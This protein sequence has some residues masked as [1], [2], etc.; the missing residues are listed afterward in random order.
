MIYKTKKN[1]VYDCLLSSIFMQYD[2]AMR[3]TFE[4]IYISEWNDRFNK[5]ENNTLVS[6]VFLFFVFTII[7]NSILMYFDRNSSH[8]TRI[9][10]LCIFSILSVTYISQF[11]T[12]GHNWRYRI[13]N[14]L[15]PSISLYGMN[16]S[17]NERTFVLR[18]QFSC[19]Y[20]LHGIYGRF[21]NDETFIGGRVSH[22]V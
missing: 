7:G 2:K 17:Y 10:K 16:S 13:Q 18:A 20:R 6:H 14:H 21:I 1:T 12:L 4:I 8:G 15:I 19:F 5:I 11:F 3:L 9:K 22:I